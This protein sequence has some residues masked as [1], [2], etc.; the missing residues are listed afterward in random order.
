[1]TQPK[2]R[3]FALLWLCLV[4]PTHSVVPKLDVLTARPLAASL[5]PVCGLVACTA[6][7]WLVGAPR[8]EALAT[9]LLAGA[10]LLLFPLTRQRAALYADSI[11]LWRDAAARTEHAVRPLVNLGTVL[12]RQGQLREAESTFMRALQR[13]PASGDVRLRLRA[14]RRAELSENQK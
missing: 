10:F 1:L 6:A 4:L 9:L 13:D 3:L 12:A 8:R 2:W 5:L 7:P 11:A 14:V